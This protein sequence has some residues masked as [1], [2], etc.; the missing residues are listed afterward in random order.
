MFGLQE[1]CFCGIIL[2]MKS[3]EIKK[4]RKEMGYT[5]QQFADAL[6]VS[7]AAV[8]RWER[9]HN[10][11]QPDRVLRIL[12]LHAEHITSAKA[13]IGSEIDGSSVAAPPQLDFEGDPEAVKLVVDAYRLRNGHLFNRAY[14]LEL[15]RVVPLPHQRIAVYEN[16]LPQAPLRFLLADDAGAGKTI[17]TGLYILEMLN[18]GRLKRV[19]ICCPKGL[20]FNWQREL[21]FFFELNF[22]IL[23][24]SDFQDNDPVSD[25]D[26]PFFII[27]VDTA[28][29]VTL[30]EKLV[31]KSG[32]GFDL[33]VF[34][35]AHKLSWGDPNRSDSKTM[36]YR[37]AEALSQRTANMLLL[38]ATPHMGKEYPYFALWRLLDP[39]VFST[40]EVL[41]NLS[42]EKRERHF[43]RRLKE[44]MVTYDGQPIYAP[45][46]TQTVPVKLTSAELRF[47]EAA[48]EYIQWS[49]ESNRALNKSAAAMVVAVLQRRLASSTQAMME[50]LRRMKEKREEM[51]K[52]PPPVARQ[53]ELERLIAEIE[54]TTAD[55]I[56]PTEDGFES[57]EHLEE[58][59]VAAVRPKTAA[60]L[61]EELMRIDAVLNLG[62]EVSEDAKFTKLRELIES[63]EYHREKVLIF[64]EHRDTLM[65]LKGQFE[66][67]G[68]TG[69][70]AVIHGGMDATERERQRAFFMPTELRSQL[71]RSEDLTRLN[72][73]ENSASLMLATDAAGEGINLQFA[74]IMV[75]YDIPWNPARLEQ[76]MGRLHRFGQRHSEVRIFNLVARDDTR[77][78]DVLAV[79]LH[80]LEEARLALSTDKVFDVVGQQL[81]ESSIRDLL[82]DTLRHPKSEAWKK[83]LD[84]MLATQKLR[85][86]IEKLRK[87]ASKYGDVGRRIGQ[88]RSEMNAENL[89]HLL[90]AYVQNFVEKCAEPLGLRLYGDLSTAARLQVRT[91]E[92][93]WISRL[94]PHLPD[95]LPDFLSVR[96]DPPPGELTGRRV[97][98]LRPG[99]PFFEGL[100][101]EIVSRFRTDTQRGAVFCDPTTE[102]PYGV[103]FYVCQIGELGH[104]VGGSGSAGPQNLLDRRMIAIKWDENGE[105]G[106]C[107]TNHLLALKAAPMSSLWRANRLLRRPD[108]QVQRCDQH[109]R[110]YVESTLLQQIRSSLKKESDMRVEDLA[111]GFDYR[112]ADLAEKRSALAKKAREDNVVT[113]GRL[114]EVKQE[115]SSL[116]DER[117]TAMLA[118]HRRT[119]LLDVVGFERV[120]VGLVIPDESPD[121]QEIYNQNIEAIAVRVARNYEV[122]RYN[123]RLIDVSAPHLARGYDLESHRANGEIVAIEVKGR[124]T[125]GVVQLTENE[126]PTAI[127]VRDRYWLYVVVD[128]STAPVLY[129]VQDP[130]YKLAVKTRQSFT[131][132]FGD[133]VREAEPD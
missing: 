109:A 55:D 91:D 45:R 123:A 78:G 111:R 71:I 16:L 13:N 122:D 36:R 118:E 1:P 89:S 81:R 128:C 120:A 42:S 124:A 104:P 76:R 61:E 114:T 64:T 17:M 117:A 130:A 52:E 14:G 127:N 46:L 100:C 75:N 4:L 70:V 23:K 82:L 125:R 86:A 3:H 34:D 95:G 92:A 105:F 24:G 93:P 37:L 97:H 26:P 28:A 74:W 126:W 110:S 85:E 96:R 27:S 116:D 67:M 72:P 12:A 121:A 102:K 53:A 66:A 33:V 20:V 106:T 65:Y 5:Q 30:R 94:V 19:L 41:R 51:A 68:Q 88:L 48:P 83:Q 103:A 132:G 49:Y 31:A 73:P 8:N 60:L 58:E 90:P 80:K 129:R 59:L 119:E 29:T 38:T 84:A 10:S 6:G 63:P 54:S 112:S 40:P 32:K 39:A 7:F 43:I 9:G 131:I 87:Q 50:S 15:S 2:C 99:D 47:Y 56:E 18:R 79:L 115:Q 44:E 21:R 133:I 62:R 25:A 69:R 108:E 11:P 57:G 22:T 113:Q 35:E 98:F 101:S 77:E 107:A